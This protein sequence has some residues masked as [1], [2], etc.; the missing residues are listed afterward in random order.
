[1]DADETD[2][3]VDNGQLPHVRWRKGRYRVVSVCHDGNVD[4]A[5]RSVG[6]CDADARN[7]LSHAA[8]TQLT[9]GSG[10]GR[11]NRG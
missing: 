2:S 1:M 7:G 9:G 10:R 8:N 6:V 3:R 4:E 11:R 5:S